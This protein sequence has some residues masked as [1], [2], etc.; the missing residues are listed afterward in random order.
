[1]V[2]RVQRVDATGMWRAR[3]RKCNENINLRKGTNA[4]VMMDA[5][6]VGAMGMGPVVAKKGVRRRLETMKGWV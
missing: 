6:D 4:R 1:M 2:W 3:V 5:E